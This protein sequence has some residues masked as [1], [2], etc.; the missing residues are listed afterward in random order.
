MPAPSARSDWLDPS[1]ADR[2]AGVLLGQACGD[3]LGAG[4]E[5]G[6]PLAAAVVVEMKGGGSFRW[7]PGE[8]TDDTAMSIPILEAAELAVADGDSLTDHLDHI[9]SRWA[10][11]ARTASDVG[12]QTRSVLSEALHN[13]MITAGS[14]LEASHAHHERHGKSAGNGSLMRTSPVAVAHLGD[15]DAM[16]DS[17]RRISELTHAEAD[18][19]DACVLWCL[20]INHAVLKGELD[21]R[22]GLEHVPKDRR[23][24]WEQRIAEAERETAVH[25]S[26]NGWVV[27]AFQAAWSAITHTPVPEPGE[28]GEAGAAGVAGGAG[29]AGA[30][31]DVG[32]SGGAT[33]AGDPHGPAAHF[34]LALENS[35]RVGNDTDTVAAIAGQLLGARWGASAVPPAWLE[36][37][38]GWPSLT[39]PDLV[40]RSLAIV[41]AG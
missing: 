29:G 21:V 8:W 20:A 37:V 36:L 18:A 17:A 14:L 30:A 2:A 32:D 9:A 6:P 11:W 34:R 15:V 39:A 4:Y 5:F 25:F 33:G 16:A 26:H 22:V 3:A 35:V 38:H 31:A 28:A 10:E 24:V 40:A 7:A 12:V 19:G 1:Q 13:G 23:A 27:H 41:P